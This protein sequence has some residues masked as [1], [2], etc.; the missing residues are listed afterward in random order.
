MVDE[1]YSW[2]QFF[3]KGGG[4]PDEGKQTPV[5]P[6]AKSTT[7]LREHQSTSRRAASQK[8]GKKG[9]A[10]TREK[11]GPDHFSAIGKK[12]GESTKRKQGPDFYSKIGK[13]GGAERGRPRRTK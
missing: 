11:Y 8:G 7:Q 13:K 10:A 2:D 4:S 1:G 5:R 12:G 3:L 6:E 9:G